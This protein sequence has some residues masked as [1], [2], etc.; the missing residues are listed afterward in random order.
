[1]PG[2]AQALRRGLAQVAVRRR[3]HP[4]VDVDQG[5]AGDATDLPLLQRAEGLH[6]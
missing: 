1:L 4:H 3:D 5:G 2:H 6:L